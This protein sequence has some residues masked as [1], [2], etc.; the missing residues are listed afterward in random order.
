M[1]R[2]VVTWG[3]DA[4]GRPVLVERYQEEGPSSATTWH[5]TSYMR[6]AGKVRDGVAV[7]DA[8]SRAP[9]NRRPNPV[10]P[11]RPAA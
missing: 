6:V 11:V 8:A 9:A 5:G 10:R 4:D 2:K 1:K 3:K 7:K